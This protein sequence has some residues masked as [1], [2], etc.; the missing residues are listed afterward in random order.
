MSTRSN[1]SIFA[2]LFK[3]IFLY[4]ILISFSQQFAKAQLQIQRI[5]GSPYPYSSVPTRLFVIA[6]NIPYSQKISLQTLQ[7]II[8]NTKP[9]I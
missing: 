8:A 3:S 2:K 7:G 6:D 5:D 1:H 4:L 9:E